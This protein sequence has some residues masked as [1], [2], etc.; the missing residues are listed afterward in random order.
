MKKVYLMLIVLIVSFRTEAQWCSFPPGRN[1][2]IAE[3]T[4]KNGEVVFKSS[5]CSGDFPY[6]ETFGGN[7]C[8]EPSPDNWGCCDQSIHTKHE[9][10]TLTPSGS[11]MA[12]QLY[13]CCSKADYGENAVWYK[14]A[15]EKV[16]CCGGRLYLARETDKNKSCCGN[17]I[18]NG[19][20]V[21]YW[22]VAEVE[23]SPD[24]EVEKIC[25]STK[26]EAPG[27]YKQTAYW[28]GYSAVCC[29]GKTY[30]R[31]EENYGCCTGSKGNN[32]THKVTTV[33]GAP[34][35]EE[36]CCDIETYGT[37]PK[38]YWNGSTAMCC[39]GEVYPIGPNMWDCC[40]EGKELSDADETGFQQCCELSQEKCGTA[41]CTSEQ[42]CCGGK[43]IEPCKGEECMICD[44]NGGCSSK[45]NEGEECCGS[46]CHESCPTG[47][48]RNAETCECECETPKKRCGDKCCEVCNEDETGCCAMPCGEGENATCC[49]DGE[50]CQNG[51][52]ECSGVECGEA[53][54]T[55]EQECCG[56]N[57]LAPCPAGQERDKATCECSCSEG[58]KACVSGDSR[59]CCAESNECGASDGQCKLGNTVCNG[60]VYCTGPDSVDTCWV[61]DCCPSGSS[62]GA[63]DEERIG[64]KT[65]YPVG[66]CCKWGNPVLSPNGGYFCVDEDCSTTV[67]YV[68]IYGIGELTPVVDCSETG[69]RPLD[70]F[71]PMDNNVTVVP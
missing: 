63:F 8:S 46:N 22:A 1:C 48:V 59:W 31:G 6:C 30:K 68:D 13:K 5:Y 64:F 32:K 28:D 56:G 19:E 36:A 9:V 41:C 65:N 11:R 53:C 47:Q 67:Q 50:T 23:G 35:G 38:G 44:G 42:E 52:C 57:C 3:G 71:D 34:N 4:T 20:V 62:Y 43:C 51:S 69:Y 39:K 54:C 33:L 26:G 24:G 15:N 49:K 55:S 61:Y 66:R 37:S 27:E 21:R 2:Q 10:G 25:C 70:I 18:S 58:Y 17:E 29:D 40:E 16:H 7:C 45:C 12:V 60:M 14:D